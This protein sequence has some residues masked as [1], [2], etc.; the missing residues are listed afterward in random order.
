MA[1]KIGLQTLIDRSIRNMGAGIHSVVKESAIEMI[2]QA[3]KEGIYVQITS[4]YRSFAEQNKLY[5]Q[6]RTAPGKIVTNAKG[7]QSNHNYGLAIDYVLLSADGKKALW[8]VNEKWRR[9]AQIGKSL[10]FSW[11]GD[12]KSFKDY[13]HLEMMGSLT[14]T[15]LQAGKRPFLVSF[16]SNKVSKKSINTKSVE[17]LLANGSIKSKTSTS[18]KSDILPSGI[19]KITKPLTKGPQVTAV[20]NALSSL[21]FYPDKGAKNN[22]IDGYYGPKT[23]NAVK[24]FQLMNGLAADGIYGPKTKNKMEQLMKK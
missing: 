3:Y 11:G 18:K 16:I 14:L 24:R 6:G 22:G 5:A 7:G 19:L 4:G 9:V 13:P 21:Y 8:T 12:W 15:Q 10:G 20:Q 1:E 23:A 17:K 2:K